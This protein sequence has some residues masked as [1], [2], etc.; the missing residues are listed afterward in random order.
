LTSD[1]GGYVRKSDRWT[2][3]PGRK[4]DLLS[5][6]CRNIGITNEV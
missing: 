3:L 2:V 6:R 1:G 4:S 5:E